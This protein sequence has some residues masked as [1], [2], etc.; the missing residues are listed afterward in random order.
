M[1]KVLRKHELPHFD[2]TRDGRDR[3]DL[4]KNGIPVDSSLIMADRVI[5]HPGDTCAKHYH[6]GAYHVFVMMYGEATVCS[7]LGCETI[8]KGQVVIMAPDEVH[9]FENH[10]DANFSLVEFW[11]PP[12]EETVWIVEDD[13]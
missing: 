6:V 4:F 12:P 11:A 7:P 10:T 3:L 5:Y 1:V 8:N 9:W 13:I 2:S